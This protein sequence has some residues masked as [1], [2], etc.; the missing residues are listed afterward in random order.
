VTYTT[1]WRLA[2]EDPQWWINDRG[3]AVR[4]PRSYRRDGWY[5]LPADKP[6]HQEFDVGPFATR[7]EAMEAA[8]SYAASQNAARLRVVLSD[9]AQDCDDIESAKWIE[10]Q[11]E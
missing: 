11:P 4:G 2:C 8:V 1:H 7:I 6:D 10:E 3:D 9:I 5:L